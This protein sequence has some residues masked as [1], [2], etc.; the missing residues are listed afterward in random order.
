VAF[1]IRIDWLRGEAAFRLRILHVLEVWLFVPGTT[2]VLTLGEVEHQLHRLIRRNVSEE[3]IVQLAHLIEGFHEHIGVR[4]LPCQEVMQGL[5]C[6][7]VV[8]RFDKRLVR[9]TRPGF[10]RDIRPQIPDDIAALLNVGGC[11]AAS[12]TVQ[13]VRTAALDLE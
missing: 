13:E 9:L 7:L 8:A 11:P 3:R 6:A 10:G 5:F 1:V 2:F 4:D 12:L